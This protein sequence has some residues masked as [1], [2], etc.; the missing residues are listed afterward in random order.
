M[1]NRFVGEYRFLS[2]FWPCTIVHRGREFRSVEH[3]YQAAKYETT[4]IIEA[5]QVA[6]SPGQ[7]LRLGR[8]YQSSVDL[9]WESRRVAVMRELVRQKFRDPVLARRLLD[10]G[11]EE[12]AEG[13]SWGDAFWGV[14]LGSGH[15]ANVLG[16]ILMELRTETLRASGLGHDPSRHRGG[17]HGDSRPN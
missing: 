7:A 6:P 15:G 17:E 1:I 12:L 2:N 14:G 8:L 13:N 10:T 16:H 5:I 11:E 4:S 9:T 3:A